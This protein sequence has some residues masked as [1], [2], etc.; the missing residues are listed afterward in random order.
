MNGTQLGAR[1]S[2]A[3]NRL[4]YCGPADAEAH[5]LHAIADG[6]DLE[7]AADALSRFEALAPYLRAIAARHGRTPFDFDVVEAYWIG[8]DLLD[9]FTREDFALILAEL[10]KHGLPRSIVARLLTRLPAHPFPHHAFHV[11]FVGVGAVTGKVETT[12]DNMEKCR[13]G[14]GRVHHVEEGRVLVDKPRL[15]L[16][17]GRLRLGPP[18]PS[19]QPLDPRL[20]PV[21]GPGDWVALH[22]GLPVTILTAT[23][24]DRLE[25]YTARSIDAANHALAELPVRK[26]HRSG[27]HDK[28]AAPMELHHASAAG[29]R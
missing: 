27:P 4:R 15:V 28:S 2:L 8:N 25:S 1:F 10:G 5:L 6:T 23:Q 29:T 11:M 13:P 17:D 18:E 20:L 22:W 26:D 21:V 24:R 9:S 16:E 7:A 19:S 3:T 12:L 14:W